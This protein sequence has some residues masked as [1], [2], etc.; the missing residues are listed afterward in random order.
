MCNYELGT[1]L[2]TADTY[3]S[4]RDEHEETP[5]VRSR[6]G[7][8]SAE[9]QVCA[10]AIAHFGHCGARQAVFLHMHLGLRLRKMP[11]LRPRLSCPSRTDALITPSAHPP[12]RF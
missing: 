3:R 8:E 7:S 12:P 2:S 10:L 1:A 4:R 11:C 5:W 9:W 6:A